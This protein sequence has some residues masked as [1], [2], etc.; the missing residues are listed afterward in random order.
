MPDPETA[1][2]EAPEAAPTTMRVEFTIPME[3]PR[4]AAAPK[5]VSRRP[6]SQEIVS[7]AEGERLVSRGMAHE[8]GDDGVAIKRT[9]PRDEPIEQRP[10]T[11]PIETT[12]KTPPRPARR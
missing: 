2:A 8:V 6:G 10:A 3:G 9:T 4:T 5:G 1:E 7:L 11:P 12:V